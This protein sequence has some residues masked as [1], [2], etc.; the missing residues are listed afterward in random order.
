M[1][2]ANLDIATTIEQART[3]DTGAFAQ[4]VRQYQSLVSGVLFS[5][6]GD[7]HKSEDFTQETFLIAW[8]KLGELRETDHLAAW[9]CTIARNL[10]HRSHRKPTIATEPLI[11]ETGGRMPPALA[12]AALA[13]DAELLRQEQSDFVWSAIGN[14]EE[15]HRE[16]LVLYYRGGQSVRDIAS[17]T[18]STEEAVRQRLVRARKSLK[19]KLEEMVGTILTDTAPGEAFTVGVL[20][21]LSMGVTAPE[22]FAATSAAGSASVAAKSTGG[23]SFIAWGWTYLVSLFN[24]LFFP[25]AIFFGTVAGAW[26]GVRNSPTLRSRRFMLK[27]AIFQ[28]MMGLSLGVFIPIFGRS[29]TLCLTM[30][31]ETPMKKLWVVLIL[32][33]VIFIGLY[34]VVSSYLINRRWRKIIEEDAAQPFDRES[35][36]R[37]SLSLRSLRGFLYGSL[38]MPII[39]LL[40]TAPSTMIVIELCT[41]MHWWAYFEWISYFRETDIVETCAAI[42]FLSSVIILVLII[43]TYIIGM[44]ITNE[45]SLTTWKPRISNYLQVLTG[46]EKPKRGI[47]YRTNFWSDLLLVGVG[48]CM[49]QGIFC[50]KYFH[51]ITAELGNQYY[52]VPVFVISFVAYLVFAILFAGVPRKR[53]F[54]YIY[55]GSFIAILNT[56]FALFVDPWHDIGA[57]LIMLVIVV[58]PWLSLVSGY[59]LQMG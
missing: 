55:L 3:G 28:A 41:S 31:D 11:D 15:K 9:L 59:H 46:E 2:T 32:A 58:L 33:F 13:P 6:T 45:N 10:V 44:K 14:I 7:F 53:Y 22:V 12:S 8:Q 4:I 17:A 47:R 30:I 5:A 40:L 21:V 38:A 42:F 56:V 37:S 51:H 23:V 52:Y 29:Y 26:N 54:G 20:A 34:C 1:S 25:L 24:A 36:E 18:E 27:A 19:A 35:L 39:A 43:S 57:R 49:L 48:L 50:E 16:T